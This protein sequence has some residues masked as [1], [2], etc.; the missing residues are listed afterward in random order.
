MVKRCMLV[1]RSEST[2]DDVFIDLVTKTKRIAA[3]N[4]SIVN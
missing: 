2:F 4:T 1:F 3:G